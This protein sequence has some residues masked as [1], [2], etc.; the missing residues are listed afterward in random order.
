[1]AKTKSTTRSPESINPSLGRL[2][3]TSFKP[4]TLTQEES[5]LNLDFVKTFANSPL[6]LAFGAEYRNETYEIG[7]GR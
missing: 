7:A 4:G 6:N 1:M 5:G 2:S 3:P